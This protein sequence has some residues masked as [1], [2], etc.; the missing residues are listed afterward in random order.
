[1]D[2][3]LEVTNPAG[4]RE[5]SLHEFIF[6]HRDCGS[7]AMRIYRNPATDEYTFTC[8]CGLAVSFPQLG[9]ASRGIGHAVIDGIPRNL[10]AGSFQSDV[11][12]SVRVVPRG[13][14]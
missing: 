2:V 6:V 7:S 13:A 4:D 5:T 3:E 11:A 8:S 14:T 9:A 12:A 1:M 10:P